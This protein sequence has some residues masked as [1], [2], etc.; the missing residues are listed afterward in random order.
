MGAH[1]DVGQPVA[2]RGG[3][4]GPGSRAV[5]GRRQGGGGVQDTAGLQGL[6]ATAGQE[7]EVLQH[8]EGE[9][10]LVAQEQEAAERQQRRVQQPGGQ[11]QVEGEACGSGRAGCAELVEPQH[12]RG[13]AEEVDGD[14]EVAQRGGQRCG[15]AGLQHQLQQGEAVEEVEAGGEEGGRGA[16]LRRRL[17]GQKQL[18]GA[19]GADGPQQAVE[20][21]GGER[22]GDAEAGGA[23]R[24]AQLD[25]LQDGGAQD[26]RRLGREGDGVD[27]P[28]QMRVGEVAAAGGAAGPAPGC[29]GR[30]RCPSRPPAPGRWRSSCTST[31]R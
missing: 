30:R 9:W 2:Q 21:R 5:L 12:R 7:E 1:V 20:Q 27:E 19:L 23:Q 18:A 28:G 17:R 3:G 11:Q 16:V 4:G 14:E 26:E 31:G 10:L 8:E 24:Q 29:C 6:Q 22:Q 25:Q 15:A 13:Q